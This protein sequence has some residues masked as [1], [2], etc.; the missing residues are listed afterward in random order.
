V[1][2]LLWLVLPFWV[3]IHESARVDGCDDGEGGGVNPGDGLL[4]DGGVGWDGVKS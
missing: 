4:E 1:D 2:S 3:D